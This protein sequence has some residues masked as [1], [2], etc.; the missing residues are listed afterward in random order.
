MRLTAMTT[1]TAMMP[2]ERMV[3]LMIDLRVVGLVKRDLL[4][5]KGAS[6]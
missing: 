4:P 1:A 5:L 2:E 6:G 3:E